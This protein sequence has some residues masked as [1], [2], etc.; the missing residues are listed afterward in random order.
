MTH[1]HII[2]PVAF[3]SDG[4]KTLGSLQSDNALTL[5]HSNLE[6][7]P[8]SIESD[9]DCLF[10]GPDTV[11]NAIAAEQ[12]GADAVIINCMRDPA[13]AA[14]RE[15]VAIPVLGTCQTAMQH[16]VLLGDTFSVIPT[17]ASGR[18]AYRRIARAYGV[19]ARLASVRPTLIPVRDIDSH[20][21]MLDRLIECATA[22]VVE[23]GASVI[24]LGCTHFAA[25]SK[26]LA[27]ALYDK[28][29]NVPLINPLSLT[30]LTAINMVKLSLTHSKLSHPL[31]PQKALVGYQVSQLVKA[32][33]VIN[34]K[35]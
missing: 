28:G 2:T 17:L 14:V 13:L 29:M 35:L 3:K 12:A 22:A 1:I 26:P 21:R 30:V 31:I 19:E 23:D 4:R 11:A 10:A 33:E 8:V 6:R 18:K 7:G 25:F 9:F 5:T 16:A 15:A 34:E 20:P 27:M 32:D 24:V